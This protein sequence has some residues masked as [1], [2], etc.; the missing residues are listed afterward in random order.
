[1]DLDRFSVAT[2]NLYNFQVPG[3]PMNPG[4]A[5][6]SETEYRRKVVWTADRLRDLLTRWTRAAERMTYGAEAAPGGVVGGGPWKVPED[7]GEALDLAPGHLTVTIGYGPSLFDDRFG[8]A[9][10]HQQRRLTGPL[11]CLVPDVGRSHRG[12]SGSTGSAMNS[13]HWIG[14]RSRLRC[15]CGTRASPVSAS[16]TRGGPS[17]TTSRPKRIRTP[18]PRARSSTTARRS[19]RSA[20]P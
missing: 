7:T 15:G 11:D 8:L 3:A 5:P 14:Q 16:S 4:Q 6:Y 20:P 2:F 13:W 18:P 10:R 19:H 1:M 9:D 17:R 12:P